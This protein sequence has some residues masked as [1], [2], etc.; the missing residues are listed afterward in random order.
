MAQ[1]EPAAGAANGGRAADA[2]KARLVARDA[3]ASRKIAR[4]AGITLRVDSVRA[5]ANQVR[6]VAG[7]VQ[8]YVESEQMGD[9][10]V[11]PYPS[12]GEDSAGR[13]DF[14][15][16][17]Q[18]TLS[19]PANRLD[20][21]LG[22]LSEVG[23]VTDQWI[24]SRDVT[25][26]YVDTQRRLKTQRTSVERVRAMLDRPTRMK[27]VVTIENELRQR[28]AQLESLESQLAAMQHDVTRSSVEV[29]LSTTATPAP[30]PASFPNG[31][32][33]GLVTGWNGF[34]TAVS[35]VVTVFGVLLPFLVVAGVVVVPLT[36]WWRRRRRQ[37][38]TPATTG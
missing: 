9:G 15:G 2:S 28:E 11:R 6:Q 8:G 7:R 25:R 1:A 12:A 14:G 32:V 35:V 36:V 21:T 3:G 29:S 17:G 10:D 24:T 38:A 5:A 19:V 34:V 13:T 18:L 31:F 20:A 27:D 23:Q 16:E 30:E 22:R 26:Q 33:Q 37:G 4:D